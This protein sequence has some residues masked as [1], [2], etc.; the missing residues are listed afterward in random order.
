MTRSDYIDQDEIR[1]I[2]IL[3]NERR[4]DRRRLAHLTRTWTAIA[5]FLIPVTGAIFAAF[6]VAVVAVV[7][8]MLWGITCL[9]FCL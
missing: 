4:K 8:A 7:A 3:R 9:A 1:R 5:D 6:V 2:L